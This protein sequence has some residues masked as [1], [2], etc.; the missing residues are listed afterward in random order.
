MS[1]YVAILL[2]EILP[3]VA[4]LNTVVVVGILLI[5]ENCQDQ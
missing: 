5:R 1:F 3:V 4:S 2:A